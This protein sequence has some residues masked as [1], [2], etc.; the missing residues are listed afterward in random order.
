MT[1]TRPEHLDA[2]RC[3]RARQ[4]HRGVGETQ[5]R[6]SAT[7]PGVACRG[8]P[9]PTRPAPPRHVLAIA[10][11]RSGGRGRA[12]RPASD[13]RRSTSN[14]RTKRR[15]RRRLAAAIRAK[16]RFARGSAPSKI[17]RSEPVLSAFSASRG[18][19]RTAF[20]WFKVQMQQLD[21]P[22]HLI[23]R[24]ALDRYR[25]MSPQLSKTIGRNQTI[26]V[27]H[28]RRLPSSV[29]CLR[30]GRKRRQTARI[31]NVVF[32][33]QTLPPRR[34][35]TR[36]AGRRGRAIM[37][38]FHGKYSVLSAW[39]HRPVTPSDC[40]ISTPRPPVAKHRSALASVAAAHLRYPRRVTGTLPPLGS[41]RQ[42]GHQ[43]LDLNA[44]QR[45]D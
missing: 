5:V 3:A 29:K 44:D 36:Q 37:Q 30:T 16:T 31:N 42:R 32:I 14:V 34:R 25:R 20:L 1:T 2:T 40:R 21:R 27:N 13:G 22:Q 45:F 9:G 38:L 43:I 4:R 15:G 7:K 11:A 33:A 8:A 39:C 17:A 23:A 26:S 18:P 10:G 12:C 28:R 35:L 24:V 41:T 6:C 19:P